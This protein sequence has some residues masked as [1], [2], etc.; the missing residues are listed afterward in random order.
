[1]GLACAW[2]PPLAGQDAWIGYVPE[3]T[4]S[5]FTTHASR[6]LLARHPCT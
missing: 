5:S 6:R 2:F 4:R 1:M 3:P